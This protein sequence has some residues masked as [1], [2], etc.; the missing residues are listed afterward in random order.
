MAK[1][2]IADDDF[3][4][5]ME[6][7]EMLDAAGHDLVGEA[8]TGK[9]AIQ[10]SRDLDP[11][12]MIIDIVMPG[13]LDGISAAEEIKRKSDTAIIFIS[14][15]GDPEYIERAKQVEPFGY[16]MKPFDEKEVKAF[17]EIALHKRDIERR[18]RKSQAHLSALF[19][20]TEDFIMIADEKGVPQSFNAAYEN[21]IKEVLGIDMKP[22]IQ[23]HKLL[24]DPKAV[25]YWEALHRRVLSGEK[26]TAEYRREM[27]PGEARYFEFSFS[28]IIESGEVR[29]FVE[30]A[31]DIT[32]RKQGEA[33]L[34]ES[35]EKYRL[36]ADN[37]S[38]NIWILDLGTMR[39]SYVSPS[40][41]NITGY[42]AEEATGFH[43]EDVLAPDSLERAAKTLSKEL[44]DDGKDPNPSRSAILELEQ[45]HKDGGTVWTEISTRFIRDA[46]GR[47]CFILGV[48][49][50]I[51]ERKEAEAALRES[52]DRFRQLFDL[53]PLAV[54]LTDPETGAILD[55]NESFSVFSNY[56]KD[57]LL[58]RTTTELGFLTS[59]SRDAFAEELLATGEING[60]EIDYRPK[61]GSVRQAVVS[62]KIIQLTGEAR[63]LTAIHDVTEQK[64]LQDQLQQA[65]KMEAIGTLAGGIAHDFNNLLMAVQGSASMLLM[66]KDSTHPEFSLIKGI[67]TCVESAADLTKQLLGFARGGKYEVKPSDLNALVKQE[68]KMFGRTKKEIK[69]HETYEDN[70]WPV[71]IDRGQIQQ[72]LLNV[73]VNAWQAM[74][75]GGDLYLRTENTTL[76][77]DNL[78]DFS[79]EPGEYARVSI[80]DTGIGMD[81]ATRERI[82]DPFFTTKEMGRGTGLGLATAFGI[83]KNHGGF[84][85]VDSE[86][87]HGSTF[88]IC[89]PASRKDV[90]LERKSKGE[91]LK[92]SETVLFVDDEEMIT[93]IAEDMLRS[94][95][96]EV[97]IA[98]NG[99]EA[100]DIF[101]RK[102]E[103]I[104]VVILDMIMPGTSGSDTFDKLKEIDP[105][106]K[107]L[108]ASGY[109]INGQAA[110]ILNRGCNGFIQKPFKMVQLSQKLREILDKK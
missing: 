48:T 39:F 20:N 31:R 36:L 32:E 64:N 3:V 26:F 108:L 11:D 49:R 80:T 84:I 30:V 4:T 51:T 85:N 71:E 1:I 103:Q 73:F 91:I 110:E 52:E 47:P 102:Q 16:V 93:E 99:K 14:G 70:L 15:Y 104:D 5:R 107:I 40:V 74:P 42:S 58:G 45:F 78:E 79:A 109:T 97:L 56:A 35:E 61:D 68:A 89:L 13:E 7:S 18:L 96:Y 62:S 50:D 82:F 34:Q 9:E 90:V 6:L 94:L 22:G 59:A 57:D 72:V 81:K 46:E 88:N 12:L 54:A 17:V 43:L 19:E 55:V 100:I 66:D 105:H 27:I 98:R 65:Q 87:G 95:G 77:K 83:I 60:M 92:G 21:I 8:E 86:K 38:D 69:I 10:L 37:I 24:D 41:K 25:Q 44:S 63:I 76:D 53:S 67:E 29:G 23:P 28:P 2:L 75:G 106:I 101:R 33:A